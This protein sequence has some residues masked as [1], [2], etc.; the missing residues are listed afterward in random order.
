MW[1]GSRREE[2]VLMCVFVFGMG[3]ESDKDKLNNF[4]H[5]LCTKNSPIFSSP[6][7]EKKKKGANTSIALNTEVSILQITTC[8][9][10]KMTL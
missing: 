5:H 9:N 3:M 4:I 6:T 7:G 2:I 10:L 1:R 8:L